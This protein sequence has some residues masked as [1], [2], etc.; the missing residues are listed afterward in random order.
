MRDPIERQGATPGPVFVAE[1]KVIKLGRGE[2]VNDIGQE[3]EACPVLRPN[4][5]EQFDLLAAMP[6]GPRYTPAATPFPERSLVNRPSS[7]YVK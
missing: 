5:R 7:L 6:Q 1:P 2:T 4:G 3:S